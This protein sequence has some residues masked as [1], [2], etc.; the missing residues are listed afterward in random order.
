MIELQKKSGH[1]NICH[2]VMKKKKKKSYCGRK[3][4]TR[5]QV[6]KCKRKMSK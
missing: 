1:R 3:N 5:E 2:L 6:K 4:P